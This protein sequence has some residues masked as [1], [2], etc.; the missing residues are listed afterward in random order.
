MADEFN[1]SI[2][3]AYEAA[4]FGKGAIDASSSF[5]VRNILRKVIVTHVYF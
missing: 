2:I 1:L 5:G 4:G 3:R